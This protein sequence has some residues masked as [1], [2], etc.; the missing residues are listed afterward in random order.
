METSLHGSG[1]VLASS[2]LASQSVSF[3]SCFGWVG[4]FVCWLITVVFMVFGVGD[5]SV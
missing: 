3:W 1:A 2:F 4:W 5:A